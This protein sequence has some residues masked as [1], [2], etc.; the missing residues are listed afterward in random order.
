MVGDAKINTPILDQPLTGNVYLRSSEHRLPDLALK[1]KGQVEIENLARIDSVKGGLRATFFTV[2]D[3]PFSTIQLNLVGGKKGLL[4]NT[5]SLC[6]TP[7]KATGADDRPERGGDE[8]E[9]E[10]AGQLHQ[11]TKAAS[12]GR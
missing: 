10:A 12:K 6:G 4:Q 8:H 7:Q 5:E 11:I 1:L 3:V 2:P 9:V